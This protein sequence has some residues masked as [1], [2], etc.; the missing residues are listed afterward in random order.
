MSHLGHLPWQATHLARRAP[1]LCS[2]WPFAH[3][4]G[5][6]Q[7]IFLTVE[8]SGGAH[9]HHMV[10]P[11]LHGIMGHHAHHQAS[12]SPPKALE[13]LIM[14]GRMQC[15]CGS[16]S[17]WGMLCMLCHVACHGGLEALTPLT[18]HHLHT[19]RGRG[20]SVGAP[21]WPP[22]WCNTPHPRLRR[23]QTRAGWVQQLWGGGVGRPC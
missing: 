1:P 20:G 8:P 14:M 21:P 15:K 7:W 13:T 12:P 22:T 5:H 17:A 11:G 10:S 2:G 19:G 6:A 3:W 18:P 4:E 9:D 16:K 23:R